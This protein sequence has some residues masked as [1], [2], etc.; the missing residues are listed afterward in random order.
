MMITQEKTAEVDHSLSLTKRR[1][2]MT[3]PLIERRNQLAGQAERMAE[4]CGQEPER[5]ERIVWQGGDIIEP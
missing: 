4:Y 2:Y 3:L 1:A 5:S